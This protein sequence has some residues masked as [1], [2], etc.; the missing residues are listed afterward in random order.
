MLQWLIFRRLAA[1]ERKLGASLEYARQL[2]RASPGGFYKFARIIPMAAYR[3]QLAAEP[4]HLAR[5]VAA[6]LE[7]C[8][9]CLQIEVNQAS[10]LGI[11][12]A[13][14]QAALDGRVDDLPP[15][16]ADVCR[17]AAGVAKGTGA[18]E[19]YRDR[20]RSRWGEAGLAELAL[21]IA[22]CRVFPTVKRALGYA[23]SCSSIKVKVPRAR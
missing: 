4:Y 12:P 5:I 11:E 18:E 19:E 8:G 21:G 2:Y 6:R 23:T 22:S 9:T 7:D 10:A 14:I 3:K 1:A 20:I 17:F 16:L 15:D 13:L